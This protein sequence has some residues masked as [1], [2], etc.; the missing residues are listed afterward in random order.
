M[1][2]NF[3]QSLGGDFSRQII[4]FD[5]NDGQRDIRCAV[6][7][8]AMDDY[9]RTRDVGHAERDAQFERLQRQ[10]IEAASRKFYRGE[11]ETTPGDDVQ[12]LV[13]R[14]DLAGI[15]RNI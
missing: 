3:V 11:F 12:V 6:S 15:P 1:P 2:L 4:R 8:V 10:I 14:A 7:Y 5:V 13:K 9:E